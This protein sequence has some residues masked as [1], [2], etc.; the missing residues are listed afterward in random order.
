MV[1]CFTFK[2]R[3]LPNAHHPYPLSRLGR[4]GNRETLVWYEQVGQDDIDSGEIVNLASVKSESPQA[5]PVNATSSS[6]VSLG[7]IFGIAIGELT[8]VRAPV[9]HSDS[10]SGENM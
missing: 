4:H 1:F 5:V 10:G 2:I 6:T 7:R 8:Y 9:R 3:G